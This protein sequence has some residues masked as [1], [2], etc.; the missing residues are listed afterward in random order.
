M[1][2]VLKEKYKVTSET[3]KSGKKKKTKGITENGTTTEALPSRLKSKL[4]K[5]VEES[6][7]KIADLEYTI[8][9][10]EGELQSQSKEMDG[11]FTHIREL[12]EKI[13]ELSAKEKAPEAKKEEEPKPKEEPKKKKD[14]KPKEEKVVKPKEASPK[15]Q[16]KVK[17]KPE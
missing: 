16:E 8:E 10:K 4:D 2:K 11:L 9:T 5:L 15:K 7:S 14:P 13:N 17:A 3:P 12:N 6:D 1:D